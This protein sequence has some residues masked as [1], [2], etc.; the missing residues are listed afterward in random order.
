[1]CETVWL[2][3]SQVAVHA[4]AGPRAGT[5]EGEDTYRAGT[6]EGED[7]PAEHDARQGSAG[8]LWQESA[9]PRPEPPPAEASNE[10]A[11]MEV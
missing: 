1:M 3:E 11:E 7:T 5:I 4:A 10:P 6:I 2:Q 9:G 8:P